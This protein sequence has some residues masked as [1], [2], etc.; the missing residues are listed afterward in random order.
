MSTSYVDTI[1]IYLY[2]IYILS[3]IRK[4]VLNDD[5]CRVLIRSDIPLFE[6]KN[7]AFK[8]FMEKY[9]GHEIPDESK[10]I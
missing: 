7:S 5:L 9:T 1:H 8:D 4:S 6:L 3:N 10:K 2:I